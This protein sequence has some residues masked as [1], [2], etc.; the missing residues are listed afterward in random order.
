V[1]S[2]QHWIWEARMG[3]KAGRCHQA[4]SNHRDKDFYLLDISFILFCPSPHPRSLG[5]C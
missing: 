1:W 4:S 3:A 5:A 2:L